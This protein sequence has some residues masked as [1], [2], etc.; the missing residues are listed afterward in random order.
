MVRRAASVGG[1]PPGSA[2]AQFKTLTQ[3]LSGSQCRQSGHLQ[4]RVC[5]S[6]FELRSRAVQ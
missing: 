4:G 2:D 6:M 3:H 5:S 1:S